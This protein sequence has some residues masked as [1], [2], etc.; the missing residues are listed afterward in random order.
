MNGLMQKQFLKTFG[1]WEGPHTGAVCVGLVSWGRDPS[2]EQQQREEEQCYKLTANP[3][4]HS[5][6]LLGVGVEG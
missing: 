2:L 3:I 6:V 4:P 5:P 1:P